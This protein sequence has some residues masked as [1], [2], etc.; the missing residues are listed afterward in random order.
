[1]EKV[2][3]HNLPNCLKLSNG[4]AELIVTTDIGP[5]IVHYA[6][7]K[8]ENILGGSP[9]V[10]DKPNQWQLWAGHRI[11]IAPEFEAEMTSDDYRNN[12]DP[13]FAAILEY[14]QTKDRATRA[15]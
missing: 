11:W 13:A 2:A 4:D 5:R 12:R 15:Q 8:G 1:M 9:G 14:L 6:L 7:A 10:L 3:W